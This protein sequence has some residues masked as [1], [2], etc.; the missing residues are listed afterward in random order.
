MWCTCDGI[1]YFR[2]INTYLPVDNMPTH[3]MYMWSNRDRD[4]P[5]LYFR[6]VMKHVIYLQIISQLL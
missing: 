6:I 3:Y 4:V 2:N 1:A 5:C